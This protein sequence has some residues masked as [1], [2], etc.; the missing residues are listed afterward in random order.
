MDIQR[1]N[2]DLQNFVCHLGQNI[3]MEDTIKL[4]LAMLSFNEEHN[5]DAV[6]LWGRVK[7][8]R[9]LNKVSTVITMLWWPPSILELLLFLRDITSGAMKTSNFHLFQK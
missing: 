2:S 7:G 9:D 8:K 4:K 1:L 6:H 3:P 5:P